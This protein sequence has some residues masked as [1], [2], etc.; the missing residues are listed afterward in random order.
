MIH[1]FTLI[2]FGRVDHS[3]D[4][5]LK[6]SGRFFAWNLELLDKVSHKPIAVC[7][8]VEVVVVDTLHIDV[9][10]LRLNLR[11]VLHGCGVGASLVI[12]SCEHGD[13][14]LLDVTHLD[15]ICRG[16][17]RKPL[18]FID[19]LLEALHQSICRP[20]LLRLNAL[21]FHSIYRREKIT[22]Y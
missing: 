6:H 17:T 20:V 8:T 3:I 21:A 1:S 12:S 5:L 7:N 16:H 4:Q 18:S 2:L 10:S 22:D 15:H 13:G 14:H 11:D 9:V 19:W